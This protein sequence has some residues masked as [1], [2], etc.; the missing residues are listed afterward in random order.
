M[1]CVSVSECDLGEE[2]QEEDGE[3]VSNSVSTIASA[4]SPDRHCPSSRPR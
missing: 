3:S 4:V 2:G 1:R